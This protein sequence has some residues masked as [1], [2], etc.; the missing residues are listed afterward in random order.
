MKTSTR[1]CTIALAVLFFI[2]G[3][4]AE[5]KGKS[6]SS[7]AR[8]SSKSKSFLGKLGDAFK[9]Q[10][11]RTTQAVK[12]VLSG[13]A[14]KGSKNQQAAPVA[15][16]PARVPKVSVTPA[17]PSTSANTKA[18]VRDSYAKATPP[19]TGPPAPRGVVGPTTTAPSGAVAG[20]SVQ[21]TVVR[22]GAIPPGKDAA[23]ARTAIGAEGRKVADG[24]H[25][26]QQSTVAAPAPPAGQT[27]NPAQQGTA[28]TPTLPAQPTQPT[29]PAVRKSEPS[30][31]ERQWEAGKKKLNQLKE[32]ANAA[33]QALVD[34][35]REVLKTSGEVLSKG[36][37]K[38]GELAS[39]GIEKAGELAN[40][41]IDVAKPYAQAAYQFGKGV[42]VGLVQKAAD[43]GVGGIVGAG[44]AVVG[45]VV[46]VVATGGLGALALPAIAGAAATGFSIGAKAGPVVLPVARAAI[47]YYH[48][49]NP[50]EQR[51]AMGK[52]L[53]SLASGANLIPGVD[54][55]KI[56]GVGPALTSV[57][58][59][60]AVNELGQALPTAAAKSA[61]DTTVGRDPQLYLGITPARDVLKGLGNL[62][63]GRAKEE[64][65]VAQGCQENP[66]VPRVENGGSARGGGS[67]DAPR[68][69][70]TQ[71]P[72]V[73]DPKRAR[74]L[75]LN[76]RISDR[77]S[78]GDTPAVLTNTVVAL[79]GMATASLIASTSKQMKLST[80]LV[81]ARPPAGPET[82]ATPAREMGGKSSVGQAR[83]LT[84]MG[85]A[86]MEVQNRLAKVPT[87]RG[88]YSTKA[89]KANRTE[90]REVASNAKALL[91]S[92]GKRKSDILANVPE[93]FTKAAARAM[94]KSAPRSVKRAWKRVA[95]AL[96]YR[97]AK[98]K[99]GRSEPPP[100]EPP[101]E[102]DPPP[103]PPPEPDPPPEPPE[104]EPPATPQPEP[105]GPATVPPGPD[106]PV[107]GNG[108]WVEVDGNRY[109]V[110][111]F[112]PQPGMAYIPEIPRWYVWAPDSGAWKA[113]PWERQVNG[114][115]GA[116]RALYGSGDAGPGTV[117]PGRGTEEG[118]NPR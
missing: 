72:L 44:L 21:T 60:M 85:S 11:S 109:W 23:A 116:V 52:G 16:P 94:A 13:G 101:P 49:T 4:V 59:K 27:P 75:A 71:A 82:R 110:W 29:Q 95:K 76:A 32:N 69:Q 99:R 33:A 115:D 92:I 113:V 43:A 55:S 50:V 100:P 78:G 105:V 28:A 112:E 67:P 26:A 104:A 54:V 6:S 46:F 61:L 96:T 77:S 3:P 47:D 42:V 48:A 53:I 8:S 45:T 35:G 38:A 63:K 97:D 107:G 24:T 17:S 31:L 25:Q 106:G 39:K 57:F 36:I 114:A 102:P 111:Q 84:A 73:P 66:P 19:S 40:K 2:A 7:K 89:L 62:F 98:S 103:E 64:I 58:G 81:A 90:L 117:A 30:W 22:S 9:S 12:S 91:K 37:E 41:A 5:G 20:K 14:G 65:Q 93:N 51:V 88:H 86:L 74:A 68:G 83:G 87:S 56:P 15:K 1:A 34:V 118:P 80:T 79:H 18:A 70:A 10:V 108:Q